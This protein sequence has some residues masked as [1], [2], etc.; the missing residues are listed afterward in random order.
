MD[1]NQQ[2]NGLGNDIAQPN[3]DS[4][5][6]VISP[7]TDSVAPDFSEPTI[8]PV[9][10]IETASVDLTA[11][12]ANFATTIETPAATDGSATDLSATSS[13]DM[14]ASTTTEPVVEEKPVVEPMANPVELASAETE[15]T[16]T[17][18]FDN[19][20]VV[21][22][23]EQA[24]AMGFTS[25]ATTAEAT[26]VETPAPAITE[27][28][29]N[30][31]NTT[32]A[33]AAAPAA[34]PKKKKTGLIIGLIILALLLIGGGIGAYLFIQSHEKPE[35]MVLDAVTGFITDTEYKISGKMSTSSEDE[36]SVAANFDTS[37][38]AG[39]FSL[40]SDYSF[41]AEEDGKTISLGAKVSAVYNAG[42][43]LYVKLNDLGKSLEEIDWENLAG[44]ELDESSKKIVDAI[45]DF[46]K[47]I[48]DN[49][50]YIDVNSE[51]TAID[52]EEYNISSEDR[53]TIA[54][55]YRNN[56]FIVLKD[57]D[58]K[59]KDGSS[60]FNV[61]FD[62][63]KLEDFT[64][65]IENIKGAENLSDSLGDMSDSF[66]DEDVTVKFT[67]G[68]KNWT[69]ELTGMTITANDDEQSVTIDLAYDMTS[70]VTIDSPEESKSIETLESDIT[71]L[72][73]ELYGGFYS[74]YSGMTGGYTNCGVNPYSYYDT[75]STDC[76]GGGYGFDDFDLDD[77]DF[78]DDSDD[79]TK[80]DF[81]N[82]ST[83][84]RRRR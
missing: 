52:V 37:V 31:V 65:A 42:D 18:A 76:I 79:D 15:D 45:V 34:E 62:K 67:I 49:W 63:T 27:P 48:E 25:A 47:K 56:P 64:K 81:S 30:P 11:A 29:N 33:P 66:D 58:V 6:P 3:F 17:A 40:T 13:F 70:A 68:V 19:E 82:L 73:T 22:A 7:N 80:I 43:K 36:G 44:E 35:K 51:D 53:A 16:A 74:A 28:V 26:P 39:S 8:N 61:S 83:R 71:N 24:S 9:A 78:E 54:E 21:S 5:E 2:N 41:T 12:D 4:A 1:P 10:D 50:Y 72:Y 84:L 38:S 77:Y 20:P 23:A 59:K 69:H 46:S 14:S 60:Y 57:A 55:A 75:N 32:A